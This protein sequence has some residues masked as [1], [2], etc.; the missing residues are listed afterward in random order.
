MH[1]KHSGKAQSRQKKR[2]MYD[3]STVIIPLIC[4]NGLKG[5]EHVFSDK[6]VLSITKTLGTG[7][8]TMDRGVV[9]THPFESTG[10]EQSDEGYELYDVAQQLGLYDDFLMKMKQ[11]EQD[12]K[13]ISLTI[14]GEEVTAEEGQ[15]LYRY[16]KKRHICT[17]SLL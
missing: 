17:S 10:L 9:L 6:K 8:F 2:D 7:N 12:R 15:N 14:N 1:I 16:V 3:S 13:Y 11:V 5:I 4:E